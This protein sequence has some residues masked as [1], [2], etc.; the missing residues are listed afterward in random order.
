MFFY[1]STIRYKFWPPNKS[2]WA[3]HQEP[4]LELWGVTK[5]KQHHYLNFL[6]VQSGLKLGK[7]FQKQE[8]VRVVERFSQIL[9][10]AL[11]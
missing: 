9:K 10:P 7:I 1:L 4:I 8:N 5:H 6:H 11:F 3:S 2:S